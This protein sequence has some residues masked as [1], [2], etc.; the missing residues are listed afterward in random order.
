MDG[1]K[2]YKVLITGCAGFIGFHCTLALLQTKAEVL[3]ID[4]LNNYYDV[5]LKTDR[6]NILR[7][8][9]NFTFKKTELNHYETLKNLFE[10]FQPNIVIHLAAQAGVRY[11]LQ[12]PLT[13]ADSNLTGFVNM[14]ECCRNYSVKHLLYA[15][16]SSVYGANHKVP[17]SENDPVEKPISLYAATKRANELLAYTYSHLFHLPC[18]GFRLFSV[19][20]EWGRPD[21]AYFR[22]TENILK[23]LPID[24]YA[25]GK[26]E[27]DFT[28]IADVINAILGMLDILPVD[29]TGIPYKIYNIGNHQPVSVANFIKTLEEIIGKK[30][31]V[32]HLPMQPGDVPK[33]YADI[34]SIQKAIGFTPSTD[35]K[36]GLQK[37][38]NWFT[39]YYKIS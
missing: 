14:L 17:F 18:T 15:S 13:F 6:L 1:N 9:E 34:S 29:E 11:S 5:R 32:R 22:F 33:T 27:R 21:M 2:N 20:G 38:V 19:Y 39:S 7:S 24:V 30:A 10:E 23:G 28:Y 35:L 4:N 8:F 26:L 16:S 12:H 36:T 31:V 3:G 25:E 37:F